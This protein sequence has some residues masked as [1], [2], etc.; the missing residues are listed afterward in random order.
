ME[1]LAGRHEP[2]TPE[3]LVAR[4]VNRLRHHTLWDF[5]LLY[6]P[7]AIVAIYCVT[8][9]YRRGWIIESAFV[10]TVLAAAALTLVVV[11]YY[12]RRA[13]P[14]VRFAAR[15]IDERAGAKDRFMTLST[16]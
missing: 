1:I 7:P 15:L 3:G 14:S 16:I 8:D 10:V 12:Y 4:L 13:L 6:L 9:L 5:L 11:M 2:E